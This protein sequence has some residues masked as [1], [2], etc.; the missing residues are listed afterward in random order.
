MRKSILFFLAIS[1]F[2]CT[3]PGEPSSPEQTKDADGATVTTKTPDQDLGSATS[4]KGMKSLFQLL[5]LSAFENTTEG[6]TAIEK[7]TL[8]KVGKSESW[9]ITDEADKT[10]SL[11]SSSNDGVALR[12]FDNSQA[13][14]GTLGIIKTRGESSNLEL[15]E[16]A[17]N[18]F[19]KNGNPIQVS[20]NDFVGAEDRLP[21]SFTPQLQYSFGQGPEIEV[22][23]R[24]WM[25]SEFEER[26]VINNV[27]LKWNGN[28]F[29]KEIV[30]RRLAKDEM[31]FTM[32]DKATYDLSKLKTDGEIVMRKFWRDANGENVVLFTKKD[33]ELFVYHYSIMEDNVK[34]L[35]RVYD[36]VKGC[37]FD[38]FLNFI[39]NSI[40]VTDIDQNGIGEITFAYHKDCISDVSPKGLNLLMLENG[41]KY[42]IRGTTTIDMPGELVEGSKTVD[43]SFSKAPASFLNHAN[44]VWDRVKT[45]KMR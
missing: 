5:P 14:G 21:D 40:G 24:T 11:S 6:L 34:Q 44:E 33:D 8:I 26:D 28:K 22:G 17:G 9:E 12:Y 15:W 13:S 39:D 4:F 23:L 42:I 7:E 38:L 35:R 41:E 3:S 16:H 19:T 37:E 31:S 43:A 36:F 10:M 32:I 18:S 20:A 2:T 45:E 27:L 1:L 29:A 30:E 25:V